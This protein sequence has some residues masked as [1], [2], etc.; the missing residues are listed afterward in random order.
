MTEVRL[1]RALDPFD[2]VA[3]REVEGAPLPARE[4]EQQH[5][6]RGDTHQQHAVLRGEP[7]GEGR[8]AAWHPRV[9]GHARQHARAVDKPRLR[10]DD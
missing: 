1:A 9:H 7:L 5:R 3:E 4:Q 6:E 2:A 8:E 10:G